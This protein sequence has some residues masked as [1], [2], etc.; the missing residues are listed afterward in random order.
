MTQLTEEELH[1]VW[2][3]GQDILGLPGN[4]ING[5]WL[6]SMVEEIRE[7]RNQKVLKGYE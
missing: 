6:M 4:D 1:I 5:E 3:F 2:D 7:W